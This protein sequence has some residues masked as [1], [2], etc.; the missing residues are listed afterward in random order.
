MHHLLSLEQTENG[1]T[2]EKELEYEEKE[3]VEKENEAT[4]YGKTRKVDT[5][6]GGTEYTEIG[7]VEKVYEEYCEVTKEV[8]AQYTEKKRI[9]TQPQ[10][11]LIEP[12]P[13]ANLYHDVS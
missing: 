1:K 2:G 5:E 6:Y 11:S 10:L 13:T 9:D 7:E 12:K 8:G 3:D 4:K